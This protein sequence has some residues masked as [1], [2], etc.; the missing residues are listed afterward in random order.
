MP[1]FSITE[2]Q[3]LFLN[4]Q[5]QEMEEEAA[6]SICM[7]NTAGGACDGALSTSAISSGCAYSGCKAR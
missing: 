2:I 3:V 6:N 4:T 5:A 1:I 7:P